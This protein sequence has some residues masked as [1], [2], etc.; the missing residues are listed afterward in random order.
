MLL[1]LIFVKLRSSAGKHVDLEP[2]LSSH[3]HRNGIVRLKNSHARRPYHC[4]CPHIAGIFAVPFVVIAKKVWKCQGIVKITAPAEAFLLGHRPVGCA[5]PGGIGVGEVQ[6]RRP[7]VFGRVRLRTVEGGIVSYL[8]VRAVRFDPGI[9][10]PVIGQVQ[11]GARLGGGRPF[12]EDRILF[13]SSLR[14]LKG[15]L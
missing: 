2:L 8:Y 15:R 4:I 5:A 7:A 12:R 13:D 1:F 11:Q 14:I 3:F 9:D 10:G 6:H